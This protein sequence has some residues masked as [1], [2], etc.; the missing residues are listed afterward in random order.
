MFASEAEIAA[1]LVRLSADIEQYNREFERATRT[2]DH[3]TK[4]IDKSLLTVDKAFSRIGQSVKLFNTALV[5]LGAGAAISGIKRLGE[6]ALN[7]ASAL[8]DVSERLGLGV[9][10]LQ[11][12]RY[13]GAQVGANAESVDKA[14]QKFSKT[15]AEAAQGKGLLVDITK[16]YGVA[17]RDENGNLKTTEELF[18]RFA[19]VI[20]NARSQQ[21]RMRIATAAFGERDG[22]AMV[23]MLQDGSDGLKTFAAEAR[24]AG[25]IIE[26]DLIRKG[27]AAADQLTKIR[28]GLVAAFNRGALRGLSDGMDDIETAIQRVG[29]QAERFGETVAEAFNKAA[30]GAAWLA[31]NMDKVVVLGSTLAGLRF[32]GLPGGVA[33]FLGGVAAINAEANALENLRREYKALVDG[34]A[35]LD[36]LR[37]VKPRL[38]E[39]EA[40]INRLTGATEKNTAAKEKNIEVTKD[41]ADADIMAAKAAEDAAKKAE[42]LWK[43]Q[44]DAASAAANALQQQ[45]DGVDDFIAAQEDELRIL[46][47]LIRGQEEEAEVQRVLLRLQRQFPDAYR[48][49][50]EGIDSVTR[51]VVEQKRAHDEN[52]KAQQEA[53]KAAEEAAREMEAIWDEAARDMFDAWRDGWSDLLRGKISS[54]EDFA[55]RILNIGV[56]LAANLLAAMTFQPMLGGIVSNVMGGG[57]GLPGMAGSGIFGGSSMFGPGGFTQAINSWGAGQGMPMTG[58]GS[59]TGIAGAGVIGGGAGYLLADLLGGNKAV[60]G[61]GGALTGMLLASGNPALAA[62]AGLTTLVGSLFGPRPSD[63]TEG[64]HYNFQTGEYTAGNLGAAKRSPENEQAANALRDAMVEFKTTIETLTG[65]RTTAQDM[66]IESGSQDGKF[67]VAID[68]NKRVFDTAEEAF[69]YLAERFVGTLEG[70]SPR[71]QTLVDGLDFSNLDAALAQIERMAAAADTFKGISDTLAQ[72]KDP[73]GFEIKQLDAWFEEMKTLYDEYGEDTADLVELYERRKLQIIERYGD[74]ALTVAEDVIGV[75]ADIDGAWAGV[76]ARMQED[77]DLR[78]SG[79][80]EERSLIEEQRGLAQSLLQDVRSAKLRFLTDPSLF[81]GS[82]KA[83]LDALLAQL[84]DTAARAE[85]GDPQARSELTQI[86]LAAAEANNRFNASSEEGNRIQEHIMSILDSTETLASRELQVAELN[87]SANQAQVDLLRQQLDLGKAGAKPAGGASNLTDLASLNAAFSQASAAASA[88]GLSQEQFAQ[89][90]L[91]A[92]FEG[93]LF[94]ILSRLSDVPTLLSSLA[95]AESQ[96]GAGGV[97]SGSAAR[98]ADVIRSQLRELGVKGYASGG[99]TGQVAFVHPGEMIY[100]GPPARVF[101]PSQTASMGAGAMEAI[102]GL[103]ADVQMLAR[104]VSESSVD[105]VDALTGAVGLLNRMTGNLERIVAQR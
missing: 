100:T 82:N 2:A 21:E 80:A 96:A 92:A 36:D 37:A 10:A 9:E 69:A 45:I 44:S 102:N 18:N 58:W 51:A 26:E 94:D 77:I 104:V 15:I 97:F 99:V 4:Q 64:G 55:K 34:A 60:G 54:F 70:M 22:R 85:A 42:E 38:I 7:A 81:R 59:V 48:I 12:Y 24:S 32:G 20:A 33:G 95:D 17:L 30:E 43:I 28:A 89:G 46:E 73:E 29:P 78:L 41:G 5:A 19:D 62:V 50:E 84:D 72:M 14:L 49:N 87:L 27:D 40:E 67:R 79:L 23:Q 8:Q 93:E 13:A 39:I 86:A 57:A 98:R 11:E 35:S 101:S 6:S 66:L 91:F 65:G 56:D 16:S 53:L 75:L 71:M 105:Q 76:L 52:T 1:L 88:S 3:R 74:E 61:G 31:E 103:R 25:I 47:L 68:E 83:H 90:N 63:R